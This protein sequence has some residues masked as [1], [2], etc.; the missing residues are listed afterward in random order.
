MVH[1]AIRKAT[2]HDHA[3]IR[4]FAALDKVLEGCKPRKSISLLLDGPGNSSVSSAHTA[5]CMS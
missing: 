2:S 1:Q 5:H 4:L 3:I